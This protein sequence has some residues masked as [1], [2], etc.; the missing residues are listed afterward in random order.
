MRVDRFNSCICWNI[1]PALE[2]PGHDTVIITSDSALRHDGLR[3]V[4]SGSTRDTA[5]PATAL[6]RITEFKAATI[7]LPSTH[8]IPTPPSSDSM[9]LA[10]FAGSVSAKVRGR[11][12]DATST[13]VPSPAFISST[14]IRYNS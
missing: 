12:R 9:I 11:S 4:E 14:R 3:P 8:F 7:Q 10:A 5:P 13:G 6:N 2:P 1:K